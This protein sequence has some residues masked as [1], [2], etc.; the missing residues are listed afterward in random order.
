MGIQQHLMGTKSSG[1][2]AISNQVVTRNTTAPTNATASYRMNA[3]GTVDL[4]GNVTS[5]PPGEWL[6]SGAAGSFEVMATVTS[7]LITG[8]TTGAWLPLGVTY[9]WSNTRAGGVPG[10]N[11]ATLQIDIRD[12]ASGVIL[13]SAGITY[14]TTVV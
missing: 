6:V 8:S 12:T 10:V 9:T 2:V 1:S 14:T 13:D 3:V 11:N 7:G 4:I 5:S